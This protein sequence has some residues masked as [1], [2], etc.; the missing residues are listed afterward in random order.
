MLDAL[1]DGVVLHLGLVQVAVCLAQLLLRSLHL[2]QQF[3]GSFQLVVELSHLAFN[4]VDQDI[5]LGI[6]GHFIGIFPTF[7]KQFCCD[8]PV[9]VT[10]FLP[11]EQVISRLLDAVLIVEYE[12]F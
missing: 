3:T 10:L 4:F 1:F 8:I 11:L 6:I 2:T 5:S 7:G 12:L 9:V